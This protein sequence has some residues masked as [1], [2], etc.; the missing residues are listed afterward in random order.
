[1]GPRLVADKRDRLIPSFASYCIRF[2]RGIGAIASGADLLSQM[3]ASTALLGHNEEPSY[4]S[5]CI[6]STYSKIPL[7]ILSVTKSPRPAAIFNMA[8]LSG[9]APRIST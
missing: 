2:R 7:S 3:Y 4:D 5:H 6:F 9:V 1:M 8:S